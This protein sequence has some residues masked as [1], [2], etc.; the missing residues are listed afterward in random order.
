MSENLEELFEQY[1]R[2]INHFIELCKDK[3]V[4]FDFDGTLSRFQYAVDSLLPCKDADIEEYTRAG[5]NIYQNI[6]VLK[7]MKYIMPKLKSDD[8]LVLTSTVPAL[9]EIKNRI[10]AENFNI[11]PEKIIHT[12]GSKE[13]LEV[14]KEIY[15]QRKKRILFVEDNYKILLDA[16]ENT[17]FVRAYHISSLLA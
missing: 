5:G 17:D 8:V 10:I 13:K 1:K 9:R 6:Y 2:N 16:E 12:N 15:A 3:T 7:T 14:L 11:A 4:V